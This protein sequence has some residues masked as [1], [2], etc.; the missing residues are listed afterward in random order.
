MYLIKRGPRP[1]YH[2]APFHPVIIC[3][4]K[5]V[6]K[7]EA[8][9]SSDRAWVWER[10]STDVENGEGFL[11]ARWCGLDI[12]YGHVVHGFDLPD[13]TP[14]AFHHQHRSLG[15]DRP[16]EVGAKF[17]G[18][19]AEPQEPWTLI[20]GAVWWD[21]KLMPPVL[22]KAGVVYPPDDFTQQ[23]ILDAIADDGCS[24]FGR[25]IPKHWLNTD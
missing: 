25:E 6:A 23:V 10:F 17:L 3:A 18:Y 22:A 9:S 20:R 14:A 16:G 7:R 21:D 13:G 11:L 2:K 1:D 15:Y 19:S 5:R 4:K 8:G 12:D 24:G